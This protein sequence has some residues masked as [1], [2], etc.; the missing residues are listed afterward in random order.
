VPLT[1]QNQRAAIS[2]NASMMISVL[3]ALAPPANDPAPPWGPL[4]PR[5][6]VATSGSWG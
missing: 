6:P 3:G 5:V 2:A 4:G 1:Y